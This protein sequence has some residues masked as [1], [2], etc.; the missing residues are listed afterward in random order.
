MSGISR[1]VAVNSI[2]GWLLSGPINSS[3][4]DVH[5]THVIIT[6]TTNGSPKDIPDDLLSRTLKQFGI[7]SQLEFSMIQ[8][9]SQVIRSRLK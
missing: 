4:N 9:L 3:N 5:R 7:V 1:P 6:D 2:F 8:S